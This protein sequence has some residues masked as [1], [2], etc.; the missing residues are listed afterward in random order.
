MDTP[1]V[2]RR[3]MIIGRSV[4]TVERP[5]DYEPRCVDAEDDDEGEGVVFDSLR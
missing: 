4:T 3:S 1:R 2:L 5:W